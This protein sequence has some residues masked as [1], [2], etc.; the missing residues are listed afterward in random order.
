VIATEGDE[1]EVSVS[2]VAFPVAR[3]RGVYRELFGFAPRIKAR[4][5]TVS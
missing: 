4:I 1:V 5:A 2:G 3:H